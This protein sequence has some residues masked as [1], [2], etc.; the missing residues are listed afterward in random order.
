MFRLFCVAASLVLRP[1]SAFCHLQY[2]WKR[3]YVAAII[4]KFDHTIWFTS[5]F[6]TKI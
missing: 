6:V 2:A 3:R 1:H 4:L 5:K